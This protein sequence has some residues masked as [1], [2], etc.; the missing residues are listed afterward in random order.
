[1]SNRFEPVMNPLE[2]DIFSIVGILLRLVIIFAVFVILIS[3]FSKAPYLGVMFPTSSFF[4]ALGWGL[5]ITLLMTFLLARMGFIRID[6]QEYL[7]NT[8]I[9]VSWWMFCSMVFYYRKKV[10]LNHTVLWKI[11]AL[12]FFLTAIL[13]IDQ[14]MAM[15]DNPVSIFLLILF[16]MGIAWV[17]V[18]E[19]IRKYRIAIFGV[20]GF[21]WLVFIFL[22]FN[23]NYFDQ[24]H[25]LAIMALLLPIPFFLLL[26]VFEQWKRIKNLEM[27]KNAAEL[28]M[29]KN[30]I[31]PHFFFNTLNN[32]YGLCVEKSDRA[33]ELVL[34][35]SEM[36]R[37][38]IYEGK[39][40]SVLLS[41]EVNYLENFLE[42][43][44]LRHRLPLEIS[45]KKQMPEDVKVS[46]LLFIVLVENA[47]KHG[48]EKLAEGAFVRIEL[49][50]GEN[51]LR[52]QI[53]N[54]FDPSVSNPEN[55]IG[56]EN[57]KR[58]LELTYPGLYLLHIDQNNSIFKVVLE[59]QWN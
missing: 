47:F 21:I 52:F 32:L 39:E 13:L 54:N 18:P 17:V 26:W 33:P 28:A 37:Y 56:L 29:L 16:W 35:L 44:K 22:R 6:P 23:G 34:K 20:Y 50:S 8:L 36:M 2:L 43:H 19:F 4:K 41:R 25:Q 12:S 42:L 59:I 46:P 15:P 58:R 14:W 11:V 31:N 38:T 45:F 49:Y 48:V 24:Y 5:A 57:L 10:K 55:G 1:M 51:K 7:E 9:L 30:Q 53:E 27:A 40:A 3:L